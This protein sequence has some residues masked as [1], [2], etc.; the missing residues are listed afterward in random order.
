[1]TSVPDPFEGHDTSFEGVRLANLLDFAS[2]TPEQKIEWLGQ[3]LE[4]YNE[5]H[6]I[7]QRAGDRADGGSGADVRAHDA[8]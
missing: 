5:I 2:A 6:G 7:A 1:M 3:M 4:L 8:G